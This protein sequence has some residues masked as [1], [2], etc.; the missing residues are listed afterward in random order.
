VTSLLVVAQYAPPSPL[1][2]ARRIGGL[3]K[4]LA[5]EGLEVTVLTSAM[6]GE[7]AV[8][9]AALVVRTG[10]LLTS[11][12]NWRR[13]S[14]DALRGGVPAAYS[15]RSRLEDVAVPDLG[16]AT[17]L[18]YA[19]PAALRLARRGRFD[20]VLTSSPPQS[21]HLVGRALRRRGIPWLAELRDG[22]TFEPPR[23]PFPSPQ[24]SL[25]ARLERSTLTRADLVLGVTQPIVDDAR[26]RL[27]VRAELVTNA[28]DPEE[29]V[30]AGGVGELVSDDRT[31]LVHTGRMAV[32]GSTPK[33]LLA[34]L[35][36]V[37]NLRERI[38]VVLAGPLSEDERGLI[39]DA[40]AN[41]LARWVGALD[42]PRTLALQRAADV[43]LVV[44]EGST[45]KSVATGK[46][47]EYLAAR[48]PI[49]V[50][51]EETEAARIV[52]ETGA[53]RATSAT[54]PEAIA[55]AIRELVERP[56]APPEPEAIERYGFPAVAA[57]VAALVAEVVSTSERS[58]ASTL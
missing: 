32:S 37:P 9:G 43:L 47:F 4:Y 25:D 51:G 45:R 19:L 40:E 17:W 11:R 23:P 13:G 27:G 30:D 56:P 48:R 18:P 38:E 35:A 8:E 34:A 20:A 49:L 29:Q 39:A 33:P 14:L 50:L 52:R 2:A 54:E 41:G 1:I 53:G 6:S 7:G 44:T 28:F 21:A 36:L 31:T 26:A 16:A 10:D 46:L 55:A 15:R 57:R 24:R 58:Q 5:R 42:R 3:A 22:W 12:L